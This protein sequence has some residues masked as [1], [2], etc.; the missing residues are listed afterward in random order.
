[1]LRRI[2]A[3]KRH[4]LLAA[5]LRIAS[6]ADTIR[7]YSV[8]A[9]TRRLLEAPS[10]QI[11]GAPLQNGLPVAPPPLCCGV[12]DVTELP[13]RLQSELDH[14]KTASLL[15]HLNLP[16][17]PSSAMGDG[18]GVRYLAQIKPDSRWTVSWRCRDCSSSWTSRVSER[19][20]NR[21]AMRFG[22]P[23][24]SSASNDANVLQGSSVSETTKLVDAFPML[25][26]DWNTAANN[27]PSFGVVDDVET[28]PVSSPAKV[29]WSCRFCRRSWREAVFA[30]VQRFTRRRHLTLQAAQAT[31]KHKK[32]CGMLDEGNHCPRCEDLM[33]PQ[34]N[35]SS[36]P[37]ATAPLLE[38]PYLMSEVVLTPGQNPATMPLGG[39]NNLTWK[40]SYCEGTY[41]A[42]LSD[43]YARAVHCPKC[44]GGTSVAP[45]AMQ[46]PPSNAIAITRPDVC[47]EIADR[48]ISDRAMR[49][50]TPTDPRTVRFLCRTCLEPYQMTMYTRCLFP[51]GDTACPKCRAAS[52]RAMRDHHSTGEKPHAAALA[53]RKKRQ[54]SN[55]MALVR[56]KMTRL[57]SLPN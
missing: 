33:V 5:P 3:Q 31:T 42:M 7:A 49:Y 40:C 11:N 25:A 29:W 23:T 26:V 36:V 41:R 32:K 50:M 21:V 12:F 4:G 56:S 47:H 30:R 57:G 9:F 20:D 22:C 35:S 38:H 24:C 39:S 17:A 28:V 53:K 45:K 51:L 10:S 14:A 44:T 43:R 27:D 13:P 2:Y 19:C 1:M 52:Q 54:T 15:R 55:N 18:D 6:L 8:L 16:H 48:T 37:A 34:N 46:L